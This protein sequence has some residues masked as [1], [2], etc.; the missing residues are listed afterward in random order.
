MVE[1]I[2]ELGFDTLELSH[3]MRITLLP[4]VEKAY[5]EGLYRVAGVHNFIPSPVEVMIDAPDC[6]EFTSKNRYE[7]DRA[8]K[9]TFKSIEFAASVDAEYIVLHMGS[10]PL[11]ALSQELEAM[12]QR[13]RLNSRKFVKK[14]LDF[15]KQ[16][17]QL[18]PLYL[19][20]ARK[21]LEL[22]LPHA[23]EHRVQ[24]GIESRSHY[25]DV[26]SEPEMIQL[27]EE[28]DSPWLGY[29][30]DFGHVQRKANLSLLN[31]EQ[32]LGKVAHRLVGCHLHDV[33][34]PLR[35]HR[36]PLTGHIDYDVLLPQIR[37]DAP[38][39]W[40]LSP[41]RRKEE[42]QAALPAW[43]HKWAQFHGAAAA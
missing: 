37:P 24:L 31:H 6:Y 35:D 9:H 3:G 36:V 5:R 21:A 26:P 22:L 38:M 17:E 28:F 11:A 43:K 40:E 8:L 12:V 27:L 32:W 18:S 16:R 4:G 42:I 2:L 41:T 13:G 34:W 1:E 7:R 25:Q 19:N 20:R 33:R 39:V 14:K 15:I 10:T 23:E 29:W 30:H